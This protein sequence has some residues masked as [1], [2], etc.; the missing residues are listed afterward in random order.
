M[1]SQVSNQVQITLVPPIAAP[2][3]TGLLN[4]LG[5]QILLSWTCATAA[6]TA[7]LL[8]KNPNNNGFSLYQTLAGSV[9]QY[10]DVITDDPTDDIDSAIYYLVAQKGAALSGPS[11]EVNNEVPN[12]RI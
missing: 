12:A 7:F 6:I 5:D 9:F 11:N 2:V 1:G 10:L 4:Q 8:Y 3:L